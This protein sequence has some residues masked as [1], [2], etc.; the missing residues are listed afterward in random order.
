MIASTQTN[1]PLAGVAAGTEVQVLV[2]E[3]CAQLK[4]AGLRITQ[5]RVAILTTLIQ[6]R[7]PASIEQIH[8]DLSGESCDLVTVYRC[9]AAFEDIGLVRRSFF[10]NGTSLYEI[11]LGR[12]NRYHVVC[13]DTQAVE[14]IEPTMTHEL[15]EAV[16][17]IEDVLRQRGYKGVT[18]MVEFFGVA[19]RRRDPANLALER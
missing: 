19:P 11:N 17:K 1:H 16:R 6:R 14:E 7:R 8:A 15:R 12:S 18:H 10:H 5:P 2:N 4:T 3:A 9:L 13:K